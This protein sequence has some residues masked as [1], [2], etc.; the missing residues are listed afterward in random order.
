[1]KL[2]I[3]GDTHFGMRNDS[4]IFHDLYKGFYLNTLIPYLE[5]HGITEIYQLGDLFDRRKY[6]NFNT[7]TLAKQ[8]FFDELKNKGINLHTLLGNHDV[9]Y[10]NTLKVNSTSLVLGEYDNIN[11]YDK[12]VTVRLGNIDLDIIP[13]ICEENEAEVLD[14][15]DRSSSEFC[16]GHFELAGFEMDRG[17]VCHEGLDAAKLSRYELVMTGHFH[18]KHKKGNILYVGSPGEITWADYNDPRGFHIFDTETREVEFIANP[19]T[20]F[21]KISFNDEEMFYNDLS[22]Y[23]FDQYKNKYVKVIV[24][25]KSN[26]FLF[27]TFID[28]LIKAG[29]LDVSVVEDFSELSAADSLHEIDQA[30]ETTTILDKYVDTIEIDLNKTKLKNIL[31]EIYTEALTIES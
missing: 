29:P 30:D 13:W 4:S 2:C 11:I 23:D 8:Y 19:Y 3:L 9:F 16:I 25:K 26:A 31:R 12:P 28:T 5:E 22:K 6:I 15:V 10:K 27:E 1:M 20:I 21:R 24:V 7:L 17:N 14:F 18:H